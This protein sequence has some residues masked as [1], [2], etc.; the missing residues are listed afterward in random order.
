MTQFSIK[1]K[2][3]GLNPIPY[4]GGGGYLRPPLAKIRIAPKRMHSLIWNFLTFNKH[5]KGKFC[6]DLNLIFLPHP[7]LERDTKYDL[8]NL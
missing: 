2:K 6:Q 3:C 1:Q 5:Q 4:K 8:K 7:L